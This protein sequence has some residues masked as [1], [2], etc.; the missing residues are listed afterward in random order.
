MCRRA[1]LPRRVRWLLH[2]GRALFGDWSQLT[3]RV[4]STAAAAAV[5][6]AAATAEA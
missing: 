4:L 5:P 2:I 1:V 6:L 3:G